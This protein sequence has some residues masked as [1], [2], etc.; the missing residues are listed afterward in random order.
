M[1]VNVIATAL[2]F[3]IVTVFEIAL[4]SATFPNPRFT[5]LKVR[6]EAAPFWPVR[7]SPQ[8]QDFLRPRRRRSKCL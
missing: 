4:F 7:S 1:L 2:A 8:M 6:G 3:F 5:G